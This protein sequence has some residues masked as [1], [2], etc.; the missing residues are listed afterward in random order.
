MGGILA[1]L[2]VVVFA[3]LLNRFSRTSDPKTDGN[4][5]HI[6]KLAYCTEEQI[7]PCVVSFGL[8]ADDNMLIN[9][10]LPNLS[11]PEF[12]LQVV[13]G[14]VRISYQCQRITGS[15]NNA[16]C[17]GAKLPPGESLHLI[18][19]SRKN[20]A[21]LAQGSLTIL[22]LAFPT[23]DIVTPTPGTPSPMTPTES[24]DFVLPTTTPTQFDD[25]SPLETP[26]QPSY[27]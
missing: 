21:I 11:F 16:Y 8:D 12:Y 17:I 15:L 26:T 7:K 20:D 5:A 2:V 6:S 13:R 10:L 24:P 19:I 27:P 22:G 23:L 25:P 3:V 1:V 9:F 14:D 4:D 18:L